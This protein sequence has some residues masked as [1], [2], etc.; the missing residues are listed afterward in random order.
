MKIAKYAAMAAG[1]LFVFCAGCDT[2]N[3]LGVRKPTASL[4]GLKFQDISLDSATLLFDVE[5]DNPYAVALP[6]VNMDYGLTSNNNP[7]L[8]GGAD[9]QS[10]I[11]AHGKKV[12][13]LPAQI[14]Y[15]DLVKAFKDFRPGSTIPYEAAVGLSV[16]APALGKLRL[17][18]SQK[19]QL[20]VPTIPDIQKIDWQKLLQKAA[21]K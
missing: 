18:I 19:G 7:L 20:A 12:V 21:T 14:K 2:L 10:T 13:S 5:V 1:V 9:V 15:L 17:P 4:Q 8:S 6:L 3:A 16:D 11:P